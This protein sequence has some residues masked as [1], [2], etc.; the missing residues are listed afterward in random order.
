MALTD[1][2]RQWWQRTLLEQQQSTHP[3]F[4]SN[5]HVTVDGDTVTLTGSVEHPDDIAQVE[6]EAHQIDTVKNVANHLTATEGRDAFHRQTVLAMF[7]DLD[8]ARLARRAMASWTMYD[9]GE[10]E[11]YERRDAAERPLREAA[12]AARIEETAVAGYLAALEGGKVLVM[13]RVSE[14]DALRLVSALEGTHAEMIRT[15][16][17]EP[18][19]VECH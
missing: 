11:M 10:A 4:G 9:D 16:P 12:E 18:E 14:D 13:D 17:P 5:V 1:E 2:V 6:Q 19:A 3:I 15:L 7:P 8:T